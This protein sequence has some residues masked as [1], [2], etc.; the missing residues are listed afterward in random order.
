MQQANELRHQQQDHR[1][2]N[3]KNQPDKKGIKRVAYRRL[4]S[5]RLTVGFIYIQPSRQWGE[6]Q[7]EYFVNREIRDLIRCRFNEKAQGESGRSK[8]NACM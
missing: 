3:T 5:I 8:Q 1:N 4:R 2:H 7:G 6:Q